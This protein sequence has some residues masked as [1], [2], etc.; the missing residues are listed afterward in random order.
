MGER[1]LGKE[2]VSGSIPL[3]GSKGDLHA[4]HN[5]ARKGREDSMYRWHKDHDRYVRARKRKLKFHDVLV[6]ELGRFRKS[7]CLGCPTGRNCLV[8]GPTEKKRQE[9]RADIAFA[10]GKEGTCV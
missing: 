4:Y 9:R 6:D 1:F 10:E 5:L 3:G 7:S 2:E 8:C